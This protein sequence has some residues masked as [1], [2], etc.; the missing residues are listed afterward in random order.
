MLK[1]YIVP[2]VA[3]LVGLVTYFGY[4]DVTTA[5]EN[6]TQNL[7]V[8]SAKHDAQSLDLTGDELQHYLKQKCN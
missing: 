4:I 7:C 1:Q 2:I 6:T 5:F 8:S 3:I